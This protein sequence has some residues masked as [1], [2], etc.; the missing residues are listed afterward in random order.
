MD[1]HFHV[2]IC[3]RVIS[4]TQRGTAGPKRENLR[5][6]DVDEVASRQTAA[7]VARGAS[8]WHCAGGHRF[9]GRNDWPACP[10]GQIRWGRGRQTDATGTGQGRAGDWTLARKV[11]TCVEQCGPTILNLGVYGCHLAFG[12]AAEIELWLSTMLLCLCGRL[13]YKNKNIWSVDWRLPTISLLINI[14]NYLEAY[15]QKEQYI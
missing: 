11:G 14:K 7:V 4:P 5:C 12:K 3:A 6:L 15:N 9:M 13:C 1:C 2:P 8:P 10:P